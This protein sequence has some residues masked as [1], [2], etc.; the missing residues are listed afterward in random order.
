MRGDGRIYSRAGTAVL[1]CEYS[2]RG[3]R[4][5]EST[6]HV[7]P[8]KAKKYLRDRLREV[9][10]DLIGARP[11]VG[12]A[13]ERIKVSC[14]VP[15]EECDCLCCALERDYELRGKASVKN[16]SNLKRVRQDF[17]AT[18]AIALTED[19]IDAYITR[20]RRPAPRLLRSTA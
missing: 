8:E 13:A 3:E 15:A 4:Y 14:D 5:R 20:R 16:L 6:G 19:A 2:L 11:F 9:G 17:G 10:A 18:A 12:P 1:W 7:D